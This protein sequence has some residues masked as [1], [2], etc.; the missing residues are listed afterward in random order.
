MSQ[1]AD[2]PSD[3]F[4]HISYY[5]RVLRVLRTTFEIEFSLFTWGIR[6]S[7]HRLSSRSVIITRSRDGVRV[8]KRAES[9]STTSERESVVRAVQRR[10]EWMSR[11]QKENERGKLFCRRTSLTIRVGSSQCHRIVVVGNRLGRLYIMSPDD[12]DS[13]DH[14]P[15]PPTPLQ[16]HTHTHYYY[17]YYNNI[18]A[19]RYRYRYCRS[20]AL[21]RDNK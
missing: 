2:S 5:P 17:Y 3:S 18:G 4:T 7:R 6:L 10:R 21:K 16:A 13:S 15:C 12:G 8:P 14:C 11:S 19:F 1:S 9:T 20:A